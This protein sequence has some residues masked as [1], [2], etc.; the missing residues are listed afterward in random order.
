M[1]REQGLNIALV[2]PSYIEQHFAH[3]LPQLGLGLIIP[4]AVVANLLRIGR[5]EQQL[6][7]N[8]Y[9]HI[10]RR[11]PYRFEGTTITID[12]ATAVCTTEKRT[13]ARTTD[14]G[15]PFTTVKSLG[16]EDVIEAFRKLMPQI[17]KGPRRFI[18]LPED[19]K[20][21]PVVLKFAEDKHSSYFEKVNFAR[22]K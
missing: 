15:M 19:E 3:L 17:P 4:T 2:M 7:G 5:G 18:L 14:Y 1:S 20:Y 11:A 10:N 21:F 12:T 16:Q 22:I 13:P 8:A 9:V 6:A